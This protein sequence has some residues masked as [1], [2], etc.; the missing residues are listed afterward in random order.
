MPIGDDLMSKIINNL[1]TLFTSIKD[2][3]LKAQR[4]RSYIKRYG[5]VICI[6]DKNDKWQI[7]NY[8]GYLCK[9]LNKDTS[10]TNGNLNFKELVTILDCHFYDL[11]HPYDRYCD[12]KFKYISEEEIVYH[13]KWMAR[14]KQSN[15]WKELRLLLKEAK[16]SWDYN[17]GGK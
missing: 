11:F 15:H 5:K 8:R 9:F 2:V 7:F 13:I 6:Y 17:Q 1:F 16:Q 10:L 3:P 12:D 4:V 14:H